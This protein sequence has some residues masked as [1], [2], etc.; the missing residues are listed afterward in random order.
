MSVEYPIEAAHELSESLGLLSVLLAQLLES[1][2]LL[3]LAA[4][5]TD[6]MDSFKAKLPDCRGLFQHIPLQRLNLLILLLDGVT[7]G[8][9]ATRLLAPLGTGVD[10]VVRRLR[11]VNLR[12][13]A[14]FTFSHGCLVWLSIWGGS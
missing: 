3:V 14:E 1:G 12:F 9:G 10:A 7:Q 6:V 5:V 8:A 4:H 13:F 2:N 11:R